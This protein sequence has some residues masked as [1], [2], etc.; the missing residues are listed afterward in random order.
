[1]SSFSSKLTPQDKDNFA[2][3]KLRKDTKEFRKRLQLH[4]LCTQ[5]SAFNLTPFLMERKINIESLNKIIDVVSE[6]LKVL[7]WE[8]Y[9]MKERNALYVYD[10]KNKPQ[11]LEMVVN[12]LPQVFSKK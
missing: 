4:I 3:L 11:E 7:G 1:M 9:H 8:V 12:M 6:E 10:P 5:S 2:E